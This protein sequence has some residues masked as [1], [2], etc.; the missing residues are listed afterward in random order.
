M[1]LPDNEVLYREDLLNF[2]FLFT[3]YKGKLECRLSVK[4]WMQVA[5]SHLESNKVSNFD[6][7][8]LLLKKMNEICKMIGSL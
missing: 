3:S 6:F 1:N 4:L 8:R 5:P 2:Y 7:I